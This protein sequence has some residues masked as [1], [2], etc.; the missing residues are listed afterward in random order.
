MI[1]SCTGAQGASPEGVNQPEAGED[2]PASYQQFKHQFLVSGNMS[3]NSVPFRR[4]KGNNDFTMLYVAGGLLV[5]TGG[6]AYLNGHNHP[7]GF[8][9]PDNTGLIIGGS[10]SAIILAV[11]HLAD[12]YRRP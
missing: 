6:L 1:F 5:V 10:F 7:E 12:Q 9:T 11:K 3:Q 8:F 4:F 2:L